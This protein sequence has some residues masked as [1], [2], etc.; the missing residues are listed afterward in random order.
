MYVEHFFHLD[1]ATKLE[2]Q[3]WPTSFGYGF[4]G[5][6]IYYDHYS[7]VIN[8]KKE[9]WAD[10][11]IR[12]IEGIFSI[13]KDYYI[14]NRIAWDETAMQHRAIVMA[15][16]LHSLKWSP[17]GRGLWAMGTEL[18]YTRGAM[19]LYNCALSCTDNIIEDLCW[20]M[21]SL[22]FGAGV[23]VRMTQKPVLN[24]GSQESNTYKIPDTREG[25][26]HSV[27]L[28]LQHY[29]AGGRSYSFDYSSIRAKGLPLKI[30]GGTASGAGPLIELHANI[31]YVFYLWMA[32]AISSELLL[33][34]LV[35][36][37]GCC[38]VTG[39]IRRSAEMIING[40][41]SA[42]RDYKNYNVNTYREPWGYM[43]NNS[44]SLESPRDFEV[45]DRRLDSGEHPG[46]VNGVNLQYGRLRHGD[47][48][49]I[50]NA[51]GVNP[52]GEIPLE[53][54]E[55]CN[56][57]ETFP[58]RCEGIQEWLRQVNNATFYTSTVALLPTHQPV[59]NATIRKNRRIGVSIVDYV[60]WGCRHGNAKIIRAMRDGYNVARITNTQLA[61]EAGVPESLRVT[62]VKPG[63]TIPKLAGCNPG[64]S[65]AN[66]RYIIR[67]KRVAKDSAI[68]DILK[69]A[70]I[71]WEDDV[72]SA[73]T[74]VFEFPMD[75][76]HTFTKPSLWQ[77]AANLVTVQ[78]EW[79]DNAVSNTLWYE[80]EERE[81]VPT[82]AANIMPVVKSVSFM[83]R[84]IMAYKQMP[85]EEISMMEYSR[86]L[87]ELS[88]IDLHAAVKEDG[89]GEQYCTGE[90]CSVP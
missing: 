55:V 84:D 30:F 32:G 8:G 80:P 24:N 76:K 48:C 40:V 7:R 38:V 13:R 70:G 67:R 56:V 59:T 88:H 20:T 22:M 75:T 54:K 44:Y 89:S 83:E 6:L 9:R 71:P 79:A 73:G 37:I 16:D 47:N 77:Q 78:R 15:K 85:E 18:M 33:A 43:S 34:D 42:I 74:L 25:W 41:N 14:K 69:R 3:S 53:D 21:D 52:C 86:R 10:T 5:E 49:R 63:G 23:T 51:V 31:D 61:N 65:Y 29:L 64:I 57:A 36:L 12:V 1:H 45:V 46:Y 90:T 62:T 81:V 19:A 17:S 11:V 66:G 87:G 35:N 27:R 68:A 82:V 50:D 2:L 58:T 28:Q 60:G 72:V 4:F 39:N 26:V